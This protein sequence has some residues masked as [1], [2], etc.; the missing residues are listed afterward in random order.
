[1]RVVS[2][3]TRDQEAQTVTN[4]FSS[5]SL[6]AV[7]QREGR[8][9][10]VD[11]PTAST[12]F[13]ILPLI[14]GDELLGPEWVN[15]LRTNGHASYRTRRRLM[16]STEGE[17]T[18]QWEGVLFIHEGLH[19]LEHITNPYDAEDK[20]VYLA[21]EVSA[22]NLENRLVKQLG[23]QRYVDYLNSTVQAFRKSMSANGQKPGFDFPAQ[24]TQMFGELENVFGRSQSPEEMDLRNIQFWMHIN[25][26]LVERYFKGNPESQK[27]RF[28]THHSYGA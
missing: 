24:P 15:E 16:V 23:G 9:V 2:S 17:M 3:A 26:E 18:P 19:A 14:Q 27:V 1:M 4:Y 20:S 10:A 13:L 7:P 25:F 28:F 6:L 21:K 11:T 8:Y 5:N 12:N 22:F